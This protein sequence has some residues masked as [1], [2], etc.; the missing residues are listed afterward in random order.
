MKKNLCCTQRWTQNVHLR[1]IWMIMRLFV[2]LLILGI[3]ALRAEESY[4]QATRI[5]LNVKDQSVKEVLKQIEERSDFFFLYNSKLVDVERKVSIVAKN[6]RIEEI[7][8]QLF[9]KTDVV[10]T[11][12][13]KQIVLTSKLKSGIILNEKEQTGEIT[14]TGTV[15]DTKTHA[16]LPGVNIRIQGT[17]EGTITDLD[18]N[19]TLTVPSAS[20][21]LSFSFIGYQPQFVIVENKTK[22]DI[23]LIEEV[24]SLDEVVVVGYGTQKKSDV[25]SSVVSIKTDKITKVA[26]LDVGEMLRGKAAGVQITTS[27]AGPGGSSSIQIRGKGS[28]AA[29]TSPIVIAD[30][31]EIGAINDINPGDIASVEILKDAAAQAIYGARAANGV[32]LIT[33]KRGAAG[34][35][36]VNYSGYYGTQQ[37]TR[38]FDVYSPEEYI[39]L[40]REAY[41]TNNAGGVYGNDNVVFSPLELQSIQNKTYIDWEDEVMRLGSIQNHELSVSGGTEKTKIYLST[42]YQETNGVVPNT[43]YKKG[44]IRFNLD[45]TVNRWMK[46]GLNSNLS[47]SRSNDPGVAGVLNEIVRSSPLGQVYNEDGSLKLHPTGFQENYNPLNDL[48]EVSLLKRSRNDLI[49]IFMDIAPFE[50]FNYRINASRRSWNFRQENYSTVN[51]NGGSAGGMG[52]GSLNNQENSS[53][54]IDNIFSYDK[55]FGNHKI[56]ATFIQSTNQKDDYQFNISFPKMPNDILGVYGLES[57][58]MWKPTISGSK[59][60]LSSLAT[61]VQYDFA[62]KYYI[63]LSGRRDGSSVFGEDNKWG[64]FPSVA[65]G[66]NVINESFVKDFKQLTN[67]KLRMSY[68]SVGNEAIGPYGSLASADQ[69]DYY[70]TDKISG[71]TPGSSLPNPK[72]KWETST[73]L[74]GALDFGFFDNR[75]TGTVEVYKTNTKN[76]LVNRN[77]NAATGYT[78]MKDNIGE[79]QNQGIELQLDGVLLKRDDLK[80]QAG[81]LFAKN[82]N[83]ILKLFGDA[84]DDGVEDDYLANNWFI[85]QPIDV[86]YTWEKLG[87]WQESEIAD[88]PNS[89]QPTVKPGTIKVEDKNGDKKLDNADKVIIS[90]MP[91]WSGSFNLNVAYKDFD[92]SMDITTVQGIL[93][94]NKFLAEYGYGGDLRGVF[95]GVKVDYWTPENPGGTFPRPTNASTPSYMDLAARQDASYIKLQNISLGYTLPESITSRLKISKLRVYCTAQNVYT[96]TKY[97]S[98]NPEQ[99]PDAYPMARTITGG[100]QLSF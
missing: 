67:L 22:L 44:M 11:V 79:I 80:I 24:K 96:F 91:N 41:R 34:Q 8:K 35:I 12:I 83:K 81:I 3:S 66:W 89:A 29:G 62:S 47:I 58:L 78:T 5:N 71:Y 9:Q 98:Y 97:Q 65:L 1:K 64:I 100:I 15:K 82:D 32:I 90:K 54:T 92:F 16:P 52:S 25:I 43:D 7:L 17:K 49:N 20:S 14:V 28:L 33:T 45:Q 39:Q 61:R 75:L 27:D 48:K 23:L 85:G 30:G 40:K 86:F 68:G 46:V 18:G 56:S 59:R 10:T 21:V 6:Q 37:V 13:D 93:K 57:S 38:N 72:L 76:L 74:N 36:K 2:M 53:W 19:F 26:T 95:N 88:I 31:V 77:L 94:Y 87:I 42:N 63:T 50:G 4:S 55:S 51:S 99:D 73:T 60:R 84:N 70:S 69:W